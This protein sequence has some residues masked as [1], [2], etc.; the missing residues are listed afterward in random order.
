MRLKSDYLDQIRI[1]LY[2]MKYTL[3]GV[4]LALSFVFVQCSNDDDNIVFVDNTPEEPVEVPSNEVLPT[5]LIIPQPPTVDLNPSLIS[6]GQDI[7]RN[8]TF[9]D[10][11]FWSGALELDKTILG[12]D[13]DGR[14]PGVSPA[15]ALQLGLKV[16]AN[17]LNLETVAAIQA[18][19]VDLTSP[20]TTV[21]LLRQNA[22]VGV[23][24]N[25]DEDGSL[26]SVG[27]NCALC[28][29]T[30][31]DSF[32][33]GIG[34]RLD[35]WA[36]RDLNVGAIIAATNVAPLAALLQVSVEDAQTVLNNWG[37]GRFDGALLLDGRPANDQGLIPAAV[38]PSIFSLQGVNPVGYAG[39]SSLS[40]WINFVAV[41]ELNAQGNYTDPRL[42]D[43][44]RFPVA[45]RSNAANR[46][47]ENDIFG[48]QAEALEEYIL[49][50]SAPEPD[51]ARF[52]EVAAIRGQNIFNNKADCVRCH[53]GNTFTDNVLRDPEEINI[54]GV[55]AN[56]FPSGQY[57]TTPLRG[58]LTK[59][60]GGYF[61]DGRFQTL[62]DVINHY[63]DSFELELTDDEKSDLEQYLN[64]L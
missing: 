64:T 27:I 15:T 36:N 19:Q 29:S 9:G 37:P 14:G 42:A 54:D 26:A 40:Q 41:I 59:E 16:D 57:R 49:S 43:E 6:Q 10:E 53:A 51:P 44:E 3:V 1:N 52:D 17:A 13:L 46:T 38:I 7:F 5:E 32:A 11:V 62:I 8:S 56:R 12:E 28:H 33:P 20:A 22:V 63:D 24:G 2:I 4:A 35:G 60:T 47:A 34:S 50:L 58:L 61:H 21:E 45:V 55:L 31:D 23:I 25:F 18:G 30:V 39:F 48:P